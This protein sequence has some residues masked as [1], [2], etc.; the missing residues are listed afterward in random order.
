[1]SAS[2]VPPPG[3][4]LPRRLRRL[5]NEA[6]VTWNGLHPTLELEPSA[7]RANLVV[8]AGRATYVPQ[9]AVTSGMQRTVTVTRR[10][11]LG[12]PHAADLGWG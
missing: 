9:A 12:W 2:P 5:A 4:A 6:V 3:L 10:R 7:P 11:H 1:M 8:L